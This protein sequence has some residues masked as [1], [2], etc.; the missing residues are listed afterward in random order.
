VTVPAADEEAQALRNMEFIRRMRGL[1]QWAAPGRAVTQTGAMRRGDAAQWMRHLGLRAP[2]EPGPPSMWNIRAIGQPW[3]IAIE[4]GMLSPSSTKVRPGPTGT[5]FESEDPV[6]QVRLG[7]SIVNLLLLQALSRSPMT[8]DC[9]VPINTI[10]IQLVAA[11]CRP[12]GQD[13]ASSAGFRQQAHPGPAR[14]QRGRTGHR[15]A[16]FGDAARNAGADPVRAVDR[17]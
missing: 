8:R 4:T 10:L 15:H 6:A 7:R 9:T 5:V 14:G 2:R 13:L 16:V 12:E 11:C 3:D 1:V 17:P